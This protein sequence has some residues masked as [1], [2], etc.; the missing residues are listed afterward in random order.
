MN[1]KSPPNQVVIKP[2]P[3]DTPWTRV[4][5]YLSWDDY[6]NQDK[7]IAFF[8]DKMIERIKENVSSEVGENMEEKANRAKVFSAAKGK[9]III[10]GNY[11][12]PHYDELISIRDYLINKH[13]NYESNLIVDF[14]EIDGLSTRQKVSQYCM[15]SRFS[16]MVDRDPSGHLIEFADMEKLKIILAILRQKGKSSTSM[17][18]DH[19]NEL[20][21][22]K[23]FEFSSSPLEVIDQ[24]VEW[25]EAFVQQRINN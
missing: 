9:S 15:V 23:I 7:T 13:S 14:P 24:A 10:L 18:N 8:K 21:H 5:L 19:L 16:I 6:Q 4:A 20:T 12:S 22:I 11:E 25:A 2:N 1:I 3:F 17:M